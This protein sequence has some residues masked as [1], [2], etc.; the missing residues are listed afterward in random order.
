MNWLRAVKF[1]TVKYYVPFY[2]N[3]HYKK[4]PNP[5]LHIYESYLIEL[6]NAKWYTKFLHILFPIEENYNEWWR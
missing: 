2:R 3:H 1:S 5:T 4:E 6:C